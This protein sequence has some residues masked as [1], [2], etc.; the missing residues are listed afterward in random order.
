LN[1]AMDQLERLQRR[2][3]G[4]Q[5]RHPQILRFHS[6]TETAGFHQPCQLAF[7]AGWRRP[8]PR[9]KTVVR[10]IEKLRI[11]NRRQRALNF[12]PEI[13]AHPKR[14]Q[15]KCARWMLRF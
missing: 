11:R 8:M 14:G 3:K 15:V 5:S 9:I 12:L 13:P 6:S 2:R 4:R 10:Y 7:R 1:R